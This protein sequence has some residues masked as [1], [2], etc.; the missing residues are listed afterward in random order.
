MR[1]LP[2]KFFLLVLALLYHTALLA[3]PTLEPLPEPSG[4][5]TRAT[6]EEL[7]NSLKLFLEKDYT[8]AE[9]A[10]TRKLHS[11]RSSEKD[12]AFELLGKIALE[13]E[14][15]EKAEEMF[16]KSL[17]FRA[18]NSDVLSYLGIAQFQNSKPEEALRSLEEA[19]WFNQYFTFSPAESYHRLSLIYQ[20]L[21]NEEEALK[22]LQNALSQGASHEQSLI[23]LADLLLKSGKR[24]EALALFAKKKSKLEEEDP[25]IQIAYARTLLTNPDRKHE[26][27][28]LANIGNLLEA[29]KEKELTEQQ[30]QQVDVLSV[31]S[32]LTIG[33]FDEAEQ[34]LGELLQQRP[35]DA[36]LLRLKDQLDIE[37]SS[38]AALEEE[39]DE[40]GVKVQSADVEEGKS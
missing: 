10:L 22:S 12:F 39:K 25:S 1:I 4:Q 3:K 16:R 18:R 29:L 20:S 6:P 27:K 9:K 35:N 38:K 14:Q 17:R 40:N 31:R 33:K 15:F 30:H 8:N 37:R 2:F 21:G 26:K 19:I 28:P 5:Q 7:Q 34:R 13:Q 32:Y 23:P 24:D 36:Y 11:L